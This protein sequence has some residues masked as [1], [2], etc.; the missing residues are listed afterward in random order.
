MF[1]K[2]NGLQSQSV[3]MEDIRTKLNF[4]FVNNR[5]G[6]DRIY[7]LFPSSSPSPLVVRSTFCKISPI[8]RRLSD[9][10]MSRQN[11][12][13]LDSLDNNKFSDHRSQSATMIRWVWFGCFYVIIINYN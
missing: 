2:V 12:A 9:Y 13:V 3:N 5:L 1:P 8:N 6:T 4:K 10:H 7:L 11:P